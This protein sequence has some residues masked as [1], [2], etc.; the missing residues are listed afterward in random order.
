MENNWKLTIELVPSSAWYKNARNIWPKPTWDKVR[1]Y[2]YKKSNYRCEICNG[3]G[4]KW[5][6]EA[7]EIWH[8]NDED[9]IQTLLD[10]QALCPEC[11]K[12]KHIGRTEMM[13]EQGLFQAIKHFC[14]VNQCSED[15]VYDYLEEVKEIWKDRSQFKWTLDLSWID[16]FL[17]EGV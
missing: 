17:K 16:N 14:K 8:Y 11:H 15:E 13:S 1:K 5:P 10:V 3:K 9:K 12:V 6:V 4:P 2:A 7:H